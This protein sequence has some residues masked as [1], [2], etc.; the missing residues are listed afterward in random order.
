M[1]LARD[2]KVLN[3]RGFIE[4]DVVQGQRFQSD[5]VAEE[6][7]QLRDIREIDVRKAEASET[8]SVERRM[9]ARFENFRLR[10]PK[11]V[12]VALEVEVEVRQAGKEAQHA[13][14]HNSFLVH[15][16]KLPAV[17]LK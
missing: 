2:I 9:E 4:P 10:H 1:R 11:I 13:R 3:G 8:V 17:Q 12:D 5:C 15:L 6:R 7:L 16:A 14:N